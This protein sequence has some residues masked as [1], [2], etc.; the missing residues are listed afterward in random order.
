MTEVWATRPPR[1][2]RP[3]PCR[4]Q[5]ISVARFGGRPYISKP[6][7]KTREAN[8]NVAHAAPMPIAIDSHTSQSGGGEVEVSRSSMA[9]AFTGG[10]KLS[11]VLNAEFG[12][13][14]IGYQNSHGVIIIIMIGITSAWAS[15]RSFTADPTAA[16]NEPMIRYVMRKKIS[17]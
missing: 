6:T 14:T 8:H 7:R 12:S 17:R 16:I 1:P 5:R 15:R 9:K 10:M 2:T 11:A 13:R 4:A 3:Y